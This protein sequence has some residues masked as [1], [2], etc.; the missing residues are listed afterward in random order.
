M[1]LSCCKKKL[2]ALLTRITS[3]HEEGFYCLNCFH[4]Y[5]TESKLLTFL[6]RYNVCKNHDCYYVEMPEEDD[7]I[8]K[9]NRRGKSMKVPFI[10]Y[11]GFACLCKFFA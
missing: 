6:K 7:K 5:I 10:I 11:A 1:A 4:S 3:K 8:L 9:Y 2:S